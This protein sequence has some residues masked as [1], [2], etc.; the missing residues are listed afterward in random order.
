MNTGEVV[1]TNSGCQSWLHFRISREDLQ[2]P[3]VQVTLEIKSESEVGEGRW[4]SIGLCKHCP[5][6]FNVLKSRR[7]KNW[8]PATNWQESSV[9]LSLQSGSSF[10]KAFYKFLWEILVKQDQPEENRATTMETKQDL[11]I[12]SGKFKLKNFFISHLCF[13]FCALTESSSLSTS[14]KRFLA[15]IFSGDPAQRPQNVGFLYHRAK[16]Q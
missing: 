12:L 6:G 9:A 11:M 15:M 4:A 16:K 3:D 14:P 5:D 10:Y 8:D 7:R 1:T 2:N 13:P